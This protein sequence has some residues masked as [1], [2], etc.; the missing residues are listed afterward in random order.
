LLFFDIKNNQ[1][2]DKYEGLA[3]PNDSKNIAICARPF[4][5]GGKK[6]IEKKM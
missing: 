6:K 5:R 1:K 3:T 4:I 2:N